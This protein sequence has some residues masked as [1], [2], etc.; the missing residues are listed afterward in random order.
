MR[1]EL[2]Q[3]VNEYMALRFEI[4][5]QE[6]E[7]VEG[8]QLHVFFAVD[9][10]GS[11]SGGPI[12]DARGALSS[13]IGKFQKTGVPTTVY[14]FSNKLLEMSSEEVGYSGM[15]EQVGVLKAGGGTLFGPVLT[16]MHERIL[17]NNLRNV[18][19]V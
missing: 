3:L 16:A 15:L 2:I 13:L 5:S 9:K 17:Q 4:P 11:M 7:V 18:F 10:S 14:L 1:A 8:E 19:C 12:Q 6:G